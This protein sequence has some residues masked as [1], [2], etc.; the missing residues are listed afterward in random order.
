MTNNSL[1]GARG[2]F[3]VI[4]IDGFEDFLNGELKHIFD[5]MC[6]WPSTKELV[7]FFVEGHVK[8]NCG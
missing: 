8:L 1:G 6:I 7:I 3:N 5:L 2:H 4:S